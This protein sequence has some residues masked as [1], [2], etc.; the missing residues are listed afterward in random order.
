MP[1]VVTSAQRERYYSLAR[2]AG[3][4]EQY[5]YHQTGKLLSGTDVAEAPYYGMVRLLWVKVAGGLPLAKAIAWADKEWRAYAVV[6][7]LQ[8][9]AAPKIR[10][11][12]S[13]GSSVISYRWVCPDKVQSSVPHFYTMDRI[14]REA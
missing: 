5:A 10:Y 8:V 14:I 11:G 2:T 13:S 4:R 3:D 1:R 7:N 9:G 12:P 6:N